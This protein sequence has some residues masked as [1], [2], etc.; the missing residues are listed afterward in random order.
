MFQPLA[1]FELTQFVGTA[2]QYVGIRADAEPAA[3]LNK[4]T[5]RE[6]AV[7]ETRLSHRAEPRDRAAP[8]KRGDFSRGRVGGVDQAPA[9]IEGRMLE[10][11]LNRPPARPGD[12]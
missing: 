5:G 2:D 8:G 11:P 4:F 1:I 10:Q 12:A 6:N 9:L 7:A 3:R